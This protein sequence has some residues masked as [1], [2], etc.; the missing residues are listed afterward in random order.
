MG[1][2]GPAMC[3]PWLGTMPQPGCTGARAL[4]IESTRGGK[5]RRRQA[6]QILM[7]TSLV[8]AP[9][10]RRTARIS[11]GPQ[12][13]PQ[14]PLV[15]RT[16]TPPTS[17]TPSLIVPPLPALSSTKVGLSGSGA[18]PNLLSLCDNWVFRRF[19][20]FARDDNSATGTRPDGVRY[21]D[22]FLPAVTLVP[23]PT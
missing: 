7:V 9:V 5:G 2:L 15:P 4:V 22:N 11:I 16:T 20:C 21:G 10:T 18:P 19:T 23:D 17:P 13:R 3:H 1:S 14:G 8:Q 6:R 12:G